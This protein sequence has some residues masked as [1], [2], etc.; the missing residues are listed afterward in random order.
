MPKRIF[1][2]DEPP[3]FLVRPSDN[4]YSY[5][6]FISPTE[7]KKEGKGWTW[8]ILIGYML[9]SLNF[10]LQGIL[11]YTVFNT[12]VL[13]NVEW[14]DGIMKIGGSSWNLF[15]EKTEGCNDG[16]SL[17]FQENGMY[18][19]APPTVQLT[20]RWEE[21]DTNKD[22]IWSRDEVIA[23]K[24][25]LKCKYAVNPVEVFD[26][27][28][29]FL[30]AREQIIWLHPDVKTGKAIHH[31]YFKYA[32]GDIIMCGYRNQDMCP[33]LL[34]RGYFH[35]PLKHNT[36]PR[37]GNTIDSALEYCYKLLA[38]G[39]T[40]EMFLPSTYSV[41][42]I[43]SVQQCL[44]P[45]YSKFSYTNPGSGVVKSLLEVDY[46]ARQDYELSQTMNFM[47]YK[48]VILYLWLLAMLVEF[49]EIV[50]LGT[51]C[52]K[53]PDA[54]QFGDDAVLEEQDPAD[55]EET[56]YR[57]QGITSGH[58]SAM[59]FL[60][61]LRFVM[62]AVLTYVGGTFLMKQTDYIDLLLDGV[63]LIFIVEIASVLYE[64]VLRDEVRDQTEDIYPMK[65]EM[66]G[67]ESLNRQP[68]LVDIICI[69]SLLA[70]CY[71]V[72]YL[73]KTNIVQPVYD[74]L[75][76]TC[77]T[78]GD[79]CV[80]AQKFDFDFWHNYWQVVVPGVFSNIEKLK[81][82]AAAGVS[83]LM[84]HGAEAAP[85]AEMRDHHVTH[86]NSKR[87]MLNANIGMK[88]HH[89]DD[90]GDNKLPA[91]PVAGSS[92]ESHERTVHHE[93]RKEQHQKH[94]KKHHQSETK[95]SQ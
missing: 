95:V 42:K 30:L 41:W 65:V 29:N 39:G 59:K 38:P 83:Y 84:S 64:Q 36:A 16:G 88:G 72:L 4:V 69:M 80:E 11:L 92:H 3:A 26:V 12:V 25:H 43:E 52:L 23:A 57:I 46:Q 6:M 74:S 17:C 63:A 8:D 60:I 49:R 28:V 40:C 9:V 85:L 67:I 24:D 87:R 44:D 10:V 20:G 66:Y 82:G 54:E 55:P 58:R 2:P 34:K 48:G 51:L 86:A 77:R 75:D 71:G 68:A 18:T 1:G 94:H 79:K 76:C 22:G 93:R 50:F 45:S 37:V 73:H 7:A 91:R 78:R 27:F 21:L 89:L 62:T 14:Q 15:E 47:L 90:N 33:N 13:E 19:C 56:R 32:M 35:A 31:E 81:T 53:Y 61:F 5:F 70:I